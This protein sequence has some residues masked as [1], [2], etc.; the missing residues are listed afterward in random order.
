MTAAFAE[1]P[2]D[3]L[4]A[5]EWRRIRRVTRA[6]DI[7]TVPMGGPDRLNCI[8]CPRPLTQDFNP[9]ARALEKIRWKSGGVESLRHFSSRVPE[10]AGMAGVILDDM[11]LFHASGYDEPQLR[12]VKAND[13]TYAG[14]TFDFHQDLSTRVL[15]C[16]NS[17]VTQALH[18]TDVVPTAQHNV[19]IPRPGAR[20]FS[21]GVGDLWRQTGFD[22]GD[23]N[24]GFIH[25]AVPIA[26]KDVPRLVLA[27]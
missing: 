20:P 13:P 5:P 26:R 25:R 18:K 11:S 17:P 3:E 15:C 10:L 22:A 6:E 1:I 24:P 27:G 8:V 16:Y 23:D 12:L 9:L 4:A 21:F 7:F 2:H 14:A 19:F